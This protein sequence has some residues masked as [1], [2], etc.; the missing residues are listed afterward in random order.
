[1]SCPDAYRLA[2]FKAPKPQFSIADHYDVMAELDRD[3]HDDEHLSATE[4]D[5]ALA[6]VGMVPR[7]VFLPCFGTG[8]HI[9]RLLERGVD[10]VVGVDLSPVCVE[11]AR[12][13]FHGDSRVELHVGDLSTWQ[14][15][16]R[17]DT[18]VLLGNSFGDIINRELLLAVTRGMVAPVR[19]GGAFVMDYIG[20]GYL[21]RCESGKTTTWQAV[22]HEQQVEDRRTPSFNFAS[23][24]MTI[25]VE[26]VAVNGAEHV[27]WRGYYQK[28]ILDHREVQHHFAEV[29]MDIRS[30]G[31]A[32]EV[33]AAYYH[34]H[35]GELGM[36]ARS[37][38]WV[39]KKTE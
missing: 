19:T 32:T 5:A 26:A 38:W 30:C 10:R 31:R 3:V 9:P 11:K 1:M 18:A 4:A 12:R 23:R 37:T 15:S 20:Q 25:N 29:G 35:E 14:T 21:D 36:I 13:L 6:L 39:G 34:G 22:L 7:S 16:E 2:M 27:L 8:R 17:F 24:V 33:N 28:L